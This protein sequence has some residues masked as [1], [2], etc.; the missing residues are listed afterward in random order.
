MNTYTNRCLLYLGRISS[1]IVLLLTLL[2]CE[3]GQSEISPI[4]VP[5]GDKLE[6]IVNGPYV[7]KGRKVPNPYSMKNMQDA[8]EIL[9]GSKDLG[10]PDIIDEPGDDPEPPD[11]PTDYYVKIT[12]RDV[13]DFD[14]LDSLGIPYFNYPLDYEIEEEYIGDDGEGELTVGQEGDGTMFVYT[15]VDNLNKLSGMSYEL[16]DECYIPDESNPGWE[17]I[18]IRSGRSDLRASDWERIAINNVGLGTNDPEQPRS[19]SSPAGWIKVLNN[20]NNPGVLEGVKGVK[21]T[22]Q[23]LVKI[24]SVQTN[25]SGYYTFAGVKSWTQNPRYVLSFRNTKDFVIWRNYACF[26]PATYNLGRQDKTGY[27]H[28][29]NTPGSS[30]WNAAVSNNAAYDYYN[31]CELTGILKPPMGLK[32]WSGLGGWRSAPMIHHLTGSIIYSWIA[33]ACAYGIYPGAGVTATVISAFL[34]FCIPDVIVSNGSLYKN[35]YTNTWHE[36]SHASHFSM[37][38]DSAWASFIGHIVYSYTHGEGSYGSSNSCNDSSTG[39]TGICGVSESWAYAHELYTEHLL[40]GRTIDPDEIS[41]SLWFFKNARVVYKLM[42]DNVL[43]PSQIFFIMTS[44]IDSISAFQS[45]L[46]MTYPNKA[47]AIQAIIDEIYD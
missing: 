23:Y 41:S 46:L 38:G 14:Y 26:M 20:V 19:G 34:S 35:V 5:T 15:T 3:K 1:Y 47:T 18:L 37:I 30:Q 42:C 45:S 16:I 24:A 6:T 28:N 2:A 11:E 4:E 22:C 12:I 31:M 9:V 25:A 39:G 10:D 7:F 29:I 44:N 40:T 32:I 43:T 27:N 13:E 8:F 21:V 17:E 33:A 36:L